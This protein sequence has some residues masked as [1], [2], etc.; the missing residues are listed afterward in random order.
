MA[1]SA[2]QQASTRETAHT[3][4]GGLAILCLCLAFWV[5][6]LILL[7]NPSFSALAERV[8]PLCT[9]LAGASVHAGADV[10]KLAR[11]TVVWVTY[12]ASGA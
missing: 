9:I 3:Q 6:G 5:S 2:A 10:A 11:R 4:D 8:L 1:E 12:I 7:E